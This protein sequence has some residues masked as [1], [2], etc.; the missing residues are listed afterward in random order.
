MGKNLD[1]GAG[2]GF[3]GVVGVASCVTGAAV[4][5]FAFAFLSEP[6]KKDAGASAKPPVDDSRRHRPVVAMNMALGDMVYFAQELGFTVKTAKDGPYESS[7]VAL[8]IENQLQKLR[9]IYRRASADNAA[10]A[11]GVLLQI[12]VGPSGEVSQVREISSFIDDADFR[13]TILAEASNW[14]FAEIVSEPVVVNCPLLFVREGMDITTLVQWEK[15]R[16]HFADKGDSTRV[17]GS[18]KQPAAPSPAVSAANAR[19]SIKPALTPMPAASTKAEPK[20]FQLKYP[21]SLRKDPSFSSTAL[22]TFAVGTK[23]A[24][25]SSRDDW[26]EVKTADNRH[27]GYIRKEFAAPLDAANE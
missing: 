15:S 20:I 24:V 3:K 2:L 16:G 14:S 23:I 19:S 4:V 18:A 8:R 22:T 26:L 5:Y 6:I 13:K 27:A 25:L 11:G 10:L 7:K 9:E 1:R 21:T 12:N 17:A